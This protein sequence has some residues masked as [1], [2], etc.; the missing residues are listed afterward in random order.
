MLTDVSASQRCR[1]NDLVDPILM[2]A[3]TSLRESGL[4]GLRWIDFDADAGTL[5]VT[6]K[7]VRATGYGLTRIDETKSE[8]FDLESSL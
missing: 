4:L 5:T 1:D 3:A 7:V 8:N 2:L 6:G